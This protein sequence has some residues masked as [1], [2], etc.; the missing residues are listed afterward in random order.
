MIE[1]IGTPCIGVEPPPRFSVPCRNTSAMQP[2]TIKAGTRIHTPMRG[3]M[4]VRNDP[5][6]IRTDALL[7]EGQGCLAATLTG[8]HSLDA[9]RTRNLDTENVTGLPLPYKATTR[10]AGLEPAFSASEAHVFPVRPLS[11]GHLFLIVDS[12]HNLTGQSRISY[13]W[14]NEE[15]VSVAGFEPALRL[16]PGQVG[17]RT[18]QHAETPTTGIEPAIFASTGRRLAFCLRGHSYQSKYSTK[19]CI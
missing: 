5:Y 17:Y 8:Q 7:I 14:T 6:R 9:T 4:K 18:P 12:N 1:T 10:Q 16:L 11:N 2:Y 15:Y 3:S 19:R 13:H